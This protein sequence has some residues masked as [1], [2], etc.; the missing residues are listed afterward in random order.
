MQL[1]PVV[2]IG[3]VDQ[4]IAD[5]VWIDNV[6]ALAAMLTTS[7]D[8]GRRRIAVL[9]GMDTESARLRDPGYRQALA[10]AGLLPTRTWRS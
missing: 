1:P 4:P 8:T 3:E 10:A 7:S 6:A 5:H 2:L 9:G